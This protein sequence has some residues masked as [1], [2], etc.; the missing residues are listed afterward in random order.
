MIETE[1]VKCHNWDI[2]GYMV[3]TAVVLKRDIMV[4]TIKGC[5]GHDSYS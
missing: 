2:Y 1:V 5:N 3:M 4:V